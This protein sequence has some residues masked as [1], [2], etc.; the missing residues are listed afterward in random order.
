MDPTIPPQATLQS[1]PNLVTERLQLTRQSP[2]LWTMLHLVM[3]QFLV[4]LERKVS[5]PTQQEI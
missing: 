1:M 4:L 3:E 5:K 2:G